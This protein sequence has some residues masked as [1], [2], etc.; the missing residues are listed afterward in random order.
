MKQRGNEDLKDFL[1]QPPWREFISRSWAGL[2]G[3]E[4]K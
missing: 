2:R 3:N 4:K 1:A